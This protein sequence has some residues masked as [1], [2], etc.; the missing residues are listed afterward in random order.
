VSSPRS[1]RTAAAAALI[2]CATFL[3]F[4][5]ALRNGFVSYDDPTYVVENP[6]IRSLG[7]DLWRGAFGFHALLWIPLVWIS[8]ALDRALFGPGPFGFHLTNVLLHSVSAGLATAFAARLLSLVPGLS[9]STGGR[10]EDRGP[11][12][13]V[14][15]GAVAAG[16]LWAI[17]PLRVESVAWITE[18]KDVLCG[19][20]AL[21]SALCYLRFAAPPA[22]GEPT[23]SWRR[24]GPTT[25]FGLLAMASKSTAVTLPVVFLSLDAW[26]LQRLRSARDLPRAAA[27][28]LPLFLASAAVSALTATAQRPIMMGLDQASLPVRALIA[29]HSVFAYLVDTAWPVGLSPFLP[30]PGEA[31]LTRPLYWAA[32]AA[33][34]ALTGAAA[35]WARRAPALAVAWLCWLTLL[36]PTLGLVQVAAQERADRFTYLPSL[37]LA[38]LAGGSLAALLARGAWRWRVG[39]LAL[40]ALLAAS[41]AVATVRQTAVW[42]DGVAFWTCA[43]DRAPEM[44]VGYFHRARDL[45]RAGALPE[46]EADLTR[47]V[48][49]AERKR[50]WHRA[51]IYFARAKVRAAEGHLRSALEDC[52]AAVALA[53]S[54]QRQYLLLRAAYYSALGEPARADA[55]RAASARVVGP[56]EPEDF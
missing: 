40:V 55:D 9:D 36:L 46:A 10:V 14:L 34:L 1:N 26:P 45:A 2:A 16:L 54:P 53:P 8:L 28:K 21:C 11:S 15:G 42:R 23:S 56:D 12:A 52:D 49:I 17:H 25:A 50:F 7:G 6:L 3:V 39:A 27:E 13:P 37:A 35:A 29:S 51:K 38:L 4:L 41:S 44:G 19:V 22:P 18:R 20:F 30:H 48:A 32:A 24:L 47:S 33:L 31:A 5:P 43:L